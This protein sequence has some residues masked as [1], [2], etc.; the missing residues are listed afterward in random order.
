MASG[1]RLTC[2]LRE[3]GV[4]DDED[5]L[6]DDVDDVDDEQVLR[7]FFWPVSISSLCAGTPRLFSKIWPGVVVVECSITSRLRALSQ[8]GRNSSPL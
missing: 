3:D 4:E 1:Y 7:L 5:E 6:E 2:V 8:N